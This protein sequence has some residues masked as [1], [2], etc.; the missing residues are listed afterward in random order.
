MLDLNEEKIRY[1]LLAGRHVVGGKSYKTGDVFEEYPSKIH[2]IGNMQRVERLDPLPPPEPERTGP[3]LT[4]KHRGMGKYHVVNVETD[5]PIH[6]GL[7]TSEEADELLKSMEAGDVFSP[8]D[9][10]PEEI[11]DEDKDDE[12]TVIEESVETEPTGTD[13]NNITVEYPDDLE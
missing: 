4:K 11:D 9:N 12:T 3:E 7:L 13:D 8:Y 1:K 6:D 2:A 5:K 10:E